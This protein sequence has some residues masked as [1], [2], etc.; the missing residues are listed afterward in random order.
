VAEIQGQLGTEEFPEV[1]Y[2]PRR[3]GHV[4]LFVSDF[5]EELSFLTDVCGFEETGRES[6]VRSGFV[7]NG[8]THHDIGF[9]DIPGWQQHSSSRI[10]EGP[11]TRGKAP[12]LN[13]LG[14][15]MNNEADL[16]AAYKRAIA[17]GMKP[18]ITHNGTSKSNYIFDPWGMQ[19]Q[20]YAD[21]TLEWRK[22]FTGGEAEFHSNPPWNP[23]EGTPT[24][25]SF[26]DPNPE[27]RRVESAALHP[28]K[29]SHIVFEVTEL[30]EHRD[31]FLRVIGLTEVAGD[32]TS[33]SYLAGRTGAYFIVLVK[34]Q[35]AGLP[36]MHHSAFE[37]WPDEDLDA[38]ATE[39]ERRE[40]PVV[41][42]VETAHKSSLFIRDPS[43][44]LF[45]FF[46]R[47]SDQPS[48]DPDETTT[49]RAFSA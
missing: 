2:G 25:E 33:I 47:R 26:W 40:V 27:I 23:L 36:R 28:V 30:V 21:D 16:V 7:S 45:E 11:P 35:G 44:L 14:L 9:I 41:Q 34:S 32:G 8:N 48:F 38:A 46:I 12:S 5:V 37:L 3:L 4:N 6:K 19:Y 15:E 13:H 24:T 18:R 22:V 43:D 39:L 29:V 31:F 42:R 20:L 1:L 17:S 10:V 49:E